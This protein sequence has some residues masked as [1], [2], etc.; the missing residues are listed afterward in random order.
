METPMLRTKHRASRRA[1]PARALLFALATA[2]VVSH[3]FRAEAQVVP[4]ELPV[5]GC[6]VAGAKAAIGVLGS[7]SSQE[8][9]T[10]DGHG[11]GQ[12]CTIRGTTGA[13][14]RR[15]I[16]FEIR[17]P[18]RWNHRFFFQGG[19]GT[20]GFLAGA[21]GA[22]QGGQAATA[23]SKGYAVISTDSGH[24]AFTDLNVLEPLGAVS[25]FGRVFEDRVD[26]GY[27]ALNVVT[28]LGKSIVKNY[29]GAPATK[30]YFV[31][32]SNGGRQ[33]FLAA[34][35]LASQYD[36][37]LAGAPAIHIAE[38]V[39]QGAQDIQV[40]G[41]VSLNLFEKAKY[42]GRALTKDDMDLV[43]AKVITACDGLDG[44]VDGIV[45][46][47]ERCQTTFK[48]SALR[49]GLLQTSGCLSSAKVTA[50]EKIMGGV[51]TSAGK[52]V[53][54]SFPWDPGIA[55]KDPLS[56][57]RTWRLELGLT[58]WLSWFDTSY[59]YPIM[60]WLGGGALAQVVS[61]PP[62][63][64]LGTGNAAYNFLKSFNVD[65]GYANLDAVTVTFKES[66]R[67]MYDVPTPTNL[68]SFQSRG[69]KLLVFNGTADPTVSA[70]D[71][72]NW[73]KGLQAEDAKAGVATSSY[74]QLYLVPGMGHCHGGPAT[75]TFDLFSVLEKWADPS[76]SGQEV[77]V[78]PGNIEAR[79][80]A[81]NADAP[82]PWRD[83]QRTR[84]LCAYPKVAKYVGPATT[85][86]FERAAN[87]RCE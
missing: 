32:C 54:A 18:F 35:R 49:C 29:Y 69:G 52:Q 43:A 31:G 77:P 45:A 68:R 27:R 15:N 4:G 75:D 82:K 42:T 80:T 7:L 78:A 28:E 12:Y 61:T 2:G 48:A 9:I 72:I 24:N 1:R 65:A 74:A 25:D 10:D 64:L 86:N 71:T 5:L 55:A 41:D 47:T 40:L 38:Q 59:G 58:S 76:L 46:N 6:D 62:Q 57:W 33:G 85:P 30:S 16:K 81:G 53:Y 17:L 84:P 60:T 23:L 19:G 14:T 83:N 36:A 34:T 8:L 50:L 79:V 26:Y 56:S 11:N 87:Y 37:V 20:D 73:Y 66:A 21:V 51:K 39:F 63:F 67:S 22:L 70:Q 44:A 3:T 13:G